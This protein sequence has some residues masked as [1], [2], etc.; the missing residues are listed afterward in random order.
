MWGCLAEKQAALFFIVQ[1]VGFHAAF[2]MQIGRGGSG[3]R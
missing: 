3:D 2:P 1:Y